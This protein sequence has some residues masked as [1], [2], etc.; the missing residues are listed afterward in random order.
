MSWKIFALPSLFIK[1]QYIVT[2]KA[3]GAEDMTALLEISD[4]LTVV[5]EPAFPL[6][7]KE[8]C[9][10]LFTL[11][12][13]R[14][15]ALPFYKGPT[16]C[17]L[18]EGGGGMGDMRKNILQTDF[19]RENK[20]KMYLGKRSCT[21][22]KYLYAKKIL[23]RLYVREKILTPEVW[24]K[25]FLSKPNHPTPLSHPLKSQLVGPKGSQLS[26]LV[27]RRRSHQKPR[28]DLGHGQK[29]PDHPLTCRSKMFVLRR[30]S[31]SSRGRIEVLSVEMWRKK[32][33]HSRY[34]V[35]CVT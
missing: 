11:R 30:A 9:D 1:E 35:V 32:F 15:V 34:W 27:P 8:D 18:R 31:F 14:H 7:N 12:S 19:E 13:C 26:V 5:W 23:K 2:S 20:G 28:A 10:E 17:L 3:P 6:A 16:T 33:F 22:K 21:E 24:E 4:N 29:I 25:K